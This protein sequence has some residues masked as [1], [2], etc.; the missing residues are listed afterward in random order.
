MKLDEGDKLGWAAVTAGNQEVVLIVSNGQAIR[1]SEEEVRCMGLPAGGVLGVKMA[2]GDQVVGM[3]VYRP[4]GDVIVISEMGVGKR[5]ALNDYPSQGR[6]GAGVATAILSTA[7]GQLAAGIVANASERLLMVSERGNSKAVYVRSLPKAG[8]AT[9]GK[10]LIAIRGRDRMATLL[11]LSLVDSE[12]AK[13]ARRQRS[14]GP[15][16]KGQRRRNPG[17]SRRASSTASSPQGRKRSTSSRPKT[18]RARSG[19]S[20]RG[21]PSTGREE[22]STGRTSKTASTRSRRTRTTSPSTAGK[23]RS[24]NR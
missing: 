4:R 20:S 5:S 7:T 17:K 13:P 23:K 16:S 2:E 18:S 3:G 24:S 10:E 8:R 6:Y 15:P 14:S 12:K 22:K 11:A 19:R 1:F 21:T 9:R